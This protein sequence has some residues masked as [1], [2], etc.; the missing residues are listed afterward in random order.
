MC[1]EKGYKIH[2]MSHRL[3]RGYTSIVKRLKKDFVVPEV[4]L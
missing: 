4:F 1:E 2:G 3:Y